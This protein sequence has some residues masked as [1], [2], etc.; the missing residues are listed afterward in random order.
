MT[1]PAPWFFEKIPDGIPSGWPWCSEEFQIMYYRFAISVVRWAGQLD[2][3]S[4]GHLGDSLVPAFDD[5]ALANLKR[6]GFS[7]VSWRVKFFAIWELPFAKK[8][9][10]RTHMN[11]AQKQWKNHNTSFFQPKIRFFPNNF[12]A[13]KASM[14]PDAFLGLKWPIWGGFTVPT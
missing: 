5:L 4:H 1:P 12:E 3:L 13:W 8:A 7:P 10:K 11:F 9:Q 2:F 6:E 14:S